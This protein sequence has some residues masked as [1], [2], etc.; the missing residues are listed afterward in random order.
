MK[1][2]KER[3]Q[4]IPKLEQQAEQRTYTLIMQQPWQEY[5]ERTFTSKSYMIAECRWLVEV[6]KRYGKFNITYKD[7]KFP[8]QEFRL[9]L[10]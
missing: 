6:L 5:L 10:L 8:G 4:V 2:R 1:R 7:S 3:W 9:E